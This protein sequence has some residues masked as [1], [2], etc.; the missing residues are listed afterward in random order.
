MGF[1]LQELHV[2]RDRDF[3][4]KKNIGCKFHYTL[5][6]IQLLILVLFEGQGERR[7][8]VVGVLIRIHV[9]VTSG[10]TLFSN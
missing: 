7:T 6:F 4:L 8:Y 3:S 10:E 5:R 9:A 1:S 2:F